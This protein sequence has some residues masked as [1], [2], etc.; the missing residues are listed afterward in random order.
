MS[1]FSKLNNLMDIT[2]DEKF[3]NICGIT[4][5]NFD[6]LF[7]GEYEGVKR[8]DIFAW[9]D[10]YSWDGKTRV[11]NPFSL[12]NF[13]RNKTFDN[14]WFDS[15]IP[16]IQIDDM[17]KR[18]E[19]YLDIQEAIITEGLLNSYEIENAPVISVLFQTGFLT[20]KEKIDGRPPEF[21]IGFPN[22][23]VSKAFSSDFVSGFVDER[24]FMQ[25]MFRTQ[26]LDAFYEGNPKDIKEPLE[27]F[28]SSFPYD[29][30]TGISEKTYHFVVSAILQALGL[31]V[32]NE[33]LQ[34]LGRPDM[35]IE[36]RKFI[37]VVELKYAEKEDGVP[38][39]I[40]EAKEQ[41]K[42]KEYAKP[43]IDSGKEVIEVAI[44][45]YERGKISISGD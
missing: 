14:Y 8:E 6:E 12:L 19:E 29:K 4:E 9:Y 37:Y 13:F 16:R 17:K 41:I 27:I 18:P 5:N 43:F 38:A 1:L 26:I 34:I 7:S 11:F 32:Q 42:E 24:T 36:T 15:G 22:I 39:K 31:S 30:F 2:L 33:T 28:L 21:K 3:A 45:F 25:R 23:E 35:V 44:C 20:V 10:G 40:K